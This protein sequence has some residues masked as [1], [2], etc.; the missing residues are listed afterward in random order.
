MS[1]LRNILLVA[2]ESA[3]MKAVEKALTDKGFAVTTTSSGE[4]AVWTLER[5]TYNCVFT[6]DVMRG[7]SGLELAGDIQARDLKLP[8]VV[9]TDADFDSRP[10]GVTEFLHKPFTPAQFVDAAARVLYITDE[11]MAQQAQAPMAEVAPKETESKFVRRI[12]GIL[13]FLM[14]PLVGL[15]YILTFPAVGVG[16]LVWTALKSKKQ[17]SESAGAAFPAAPVNPSLVKVFAWIPVIFLT[18]VAFAVAGPILGIG[19]LL[20]L[21]LEAWGKIGAKA[22]SE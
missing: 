19:L 16:I 4:D 11:E 6:E 22:L 20:W 13:L 8:V 2:H 18:G 9:M 14:A 7:M 15:V 3:E 12:K 10:P 1:N 17:K 5:G 21:S